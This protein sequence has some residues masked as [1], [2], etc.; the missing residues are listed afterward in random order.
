MIL[1]SGSLLFPID[2][3]TNLRLAY[4]KTTDL[5]AFYWW[6]KNAVGSSASA[7]NTDGLRKHL[8]TDTGF[9]WL[10]FKIVYK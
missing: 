7:S 10:S 9:G 1:R 5:G 2:Y 8:T 3:C 4:Q 6:K